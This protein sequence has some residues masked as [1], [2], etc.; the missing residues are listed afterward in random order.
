MSGSA[1]ARSAV[2]ASTIRSMI[3]R[4]QRCFGWPGAP[5]GITYAAEYIV[6]PCAFIASS[7]SRVLRR[8]S[9]CQRGSSPSAV[10]LSQVSIRLKNLKSRIRSRIVRSSSP[11]LSWMIRII[12]W[13]TRSAAR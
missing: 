4:F 11:A 5:A 8:L 13:L 2:P 12:A 1:A 3:S 9:G 10:R 6:R 7:R